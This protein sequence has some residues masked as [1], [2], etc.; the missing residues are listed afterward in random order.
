[1]FISLNGGASAAETATLLR[2]GTLSLSGPLF[3]AVNSAVTFSGPALLAAQANSSLT[4]TG[5][6]PFVSFTGGS[7]TLG[8][9]TN[10]VSLDSG[11][12]PSLAGPP[13]TPHG[14]PTT[15][16]TDLLT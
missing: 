15:G 7:L 12:A 14:T 6:S 8:T 4:G 16:G 5:S 1:P 2:N 10:G 11:S 13:L 3:D 9:R